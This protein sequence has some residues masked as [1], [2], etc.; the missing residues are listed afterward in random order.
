MVKNHDQKW[1]TEALHEVATCD[2]VCEV[3]VV[4]FSQ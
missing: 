4:G 3:L 2:G 1:P